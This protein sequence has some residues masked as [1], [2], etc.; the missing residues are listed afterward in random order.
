M[1]T[2]FLTKIIEHKEQEI[3]RARALVPEARLREQAESRQ[4]R[5]PFFENLKRPGVN[6]I[7][8]IKRASPSKGDIR[9]DLDAAG[10]AKAYEKGGAAALSVLTDKTFFKGSAEDLK[11][12]RAATSLPVLRKDFLISE[13]QIYEAAAMGADAALLIARCLSPSRLKDLA[14]LAR[15]LNLDT[16]VEIHSEE[17]LASAAG[18]GAELIGIN[19]RNLQTFETDLDIAMRLASMLLPNQVP[20]AASGIRDRKDIENNLEFGLHNFLIGETLVRS[21]DPEG[22]VRSLIGEPRREKKT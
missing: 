13:Y 10:L 5:R 9:I 1:G 6:I 20:V 16:L 15:Q 3:E 21:D 14:A 7:A 18:A 11:T 17:D 2:D 19:N 22:L 8:E 4:D 12:A